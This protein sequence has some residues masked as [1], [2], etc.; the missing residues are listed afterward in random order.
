VTS[1]QDAASGVA[2]RGVGVVDDRLEDI[3]LLL[4]LVRT[5]RAKTRTELSRRSGLSRKVLGQ[6][7]GDLL[8]HGLVTEGDLAPSTGGRAP[9][10]LAFRGD[11]GA[12][13][14]AQFGATGMGIG[15]ADL[16]GTVLRRHHEPLDIA[17]GPDC[18]LG[19]AEELFDRMLGERGDDA[20]PIWG[21]GLGVPGPVE[22]DS[23]TPIAPPIMP[24]W[25]GYPV[26][27]RLAQRFGVPTWLDNDVNLMALGELRAG[28]AR[29]QDNV[30]YMKV[31]TGI[32][33]GLVSRGRLHRGANG[34]AGDVGHVA[35]RSD[36]PALCRCGKIDCLEAHAGGAALA[37]DA[38]TAAQEGTSAF[39]AARLAEHGPL[40]ARDIADAAAAG[41]AVAIS[42]LTRSGRLV[43]ET[44]ATLV[45]FFNPSTII[46]GGRVT[47]TSDLVLAAVRQAVYRQSL[48]LATR[49]L[50]IAQSVNSAE[51]GLVGAAFMVVDEL[52]DAPVLARW[53]GDG[54]PAGR[55]ELSTAA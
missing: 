42:L 18:A 9:R 25:D 38:T 21:V 11:A 28:L 17:V 23:G 8:T 3:A 48:P 15:I 22:F 45:N 2:T 51:I 39:L 19:R 37:R 46:I 49:D 44:L 54:S 30:V 20:P 36:H 33:A 13:L 43:G 16:T 31:G 12:V 32:G 7:L 50:H 34:T 5:G 24:G 14:V 53:I 4:D 26:R 40:H 6:R 10:E 29:G 35:V 41:D 55:P 1:G 27:N 47:T 52:F